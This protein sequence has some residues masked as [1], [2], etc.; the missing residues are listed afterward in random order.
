M[1]ARRD[2]CV[3]IG[4]KMEQVETLTH[5]ITLCTRCFSKTLTRMVELE[6]IHK[7]YRIYGITTT[8]IRY[9]QVAMDDYEAED[10]RLEVSKRW[11]AAM[12]ELADFVVE[13][14]HGDPLAGEYLPDGTQIK[15]YVR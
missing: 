1:V 6:P 11:L 7:K 10:R 15:V 14:P 8:T 12:K 13:V 2:S 5:V 4:H 9:Y 3:A